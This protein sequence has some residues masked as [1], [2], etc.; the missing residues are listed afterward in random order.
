MSHICIT[1]IMCIVFI[2]V[3]HGGGVSS[4]TITPSCEAVERGNTGDFC[5]DLKKQLTELLSGAGH[6]DGSRKSDEKKHPSCNAVRNLT[7]L[8][9]MKIEVKNSKR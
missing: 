6:T 7:S 8:A 1:S 4:Y 2:E 5:T 3:I 9:G